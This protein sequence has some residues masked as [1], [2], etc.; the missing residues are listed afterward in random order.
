M[1]YCNYEKEKE[2]LIN[3]VLE[4]HSLDFDIDDMNTIISQKPTKD[5]LLLQYPLIQHSHLYL[6]YLS[7]D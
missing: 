4:A 3:R 2:E 7:N 6:Y 5:K 1:G